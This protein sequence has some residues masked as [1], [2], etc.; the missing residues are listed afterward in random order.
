MKRLGPLLEEALGTEGLG[1][2]PD[3]HLGDKRS[4]KSNRYVS[5]KREL[6]DRFVWGGVG[7]REK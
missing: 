4:T 5:F 1:Q 7:I 3:T 2:G 6:A